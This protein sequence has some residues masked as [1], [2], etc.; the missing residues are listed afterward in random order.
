MLVVR[1]QNGAIVQ[2]GEELEVRS[3]GAL[4]AKWFV[5][6]IDADK[7]EIVVDHTD[8]AGDFTP[9]LRI[10]INMWEGAEVIELTANDIN[11]DPNLAFRLKKED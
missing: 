5:K 3:D 6:E 7:M 1:L 4:F 2:T 11:K 8:A 9:D 10:P